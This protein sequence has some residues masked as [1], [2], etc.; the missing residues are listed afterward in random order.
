MRVLALSLMVC[1]IHHTVL[2]QKIPVQVQISEPLPSGSDN[3]GSIFEMPEIIASSLE[4]S[5]M[6]PLVIEK[7]GVDEYGNEFYEKQIIAK[8]L[9]GDLNGEMNMMQS[10]MISSPMK[11]PF[12]SAAPSMFLQDSP[13]GSSSSPMSSS[14]LSLIMQTIMARER[15][16]AAES[17]NQSPQLIMSPFDEQQSAAKRMI[18]FFPSSSSPFES[19]ESRMLSPME[20]QQRNIIVPQPSMSSMFMNSI[21]NEM[22]QG[23]DAN[24]D[25]GDDDDNDEDET[26]ENGEVKSIIGSEDNDDDNDNDKADEEKENEKLNMAKEERDEQL[27][28][29]SIDETPDEDDKVVFDMRDELEDENKLDKQTLEQIKLSLDKNQKQYVSRLLG[30]K[31]FPMDQASEK[32]YADS[33]NNNNN[34][35]NNELNNIHS[36]K[37]DDSFVYIK[38]DKN[39]NSSQT[40]ALLKYIA[41]FTSVPF[42][43][44]TDITVSEN[45]ILFRLDKEKYP[46][47]DLNQLVAEIVKHKEKI[48]RELGLSIVACNRGNYL[49]SELRPLRI[50]N[51]KSK[52]F[53]LVT[54]VLCSTTLVLLIVLLT[55]FVVRRRAYLRR[56]LVS[57]LNSLSGKA[58][59]ATGKGKFDDEEQLVSDDFKTPKRGVTR[60]LLNSFWPFSKSAGSRTDD[61]G[62]DITPTQDYKEL[63]RQR[64]HVKGGQMTPL[65]TTLI[66]GGGI[67]SSLN[68]SAAHVPNMSMTT[69]VRTNSAESKTGASGSSSR[70]STSS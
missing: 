56:Q 18:F 53:L 39:I 21:M 65:S 50:I 44:F 70:S 23:E 8:S 59:S 41:R 28:L 20:T 54:V 31:A 30:K 11:M 37:I 4:D 1:L 34:N 16:A 22:M 64:M 33:Y 46:N 47:G 43:W 38:L 26:K 13:Y 63:C 35:N 42:E 14:L 3:F 49:L 67:N 15:A 6:G 19:S 29:L 7:E 48:Q 27:Q 52:Y 24:D 55:I 32:I 60:G 45:L 66:S 36:L 12:N 57:N 9:Q 5:V 62:K 10:H 69:P 2:S 25:D 61:T 58:A 17:M 40:D 51:S 68:T